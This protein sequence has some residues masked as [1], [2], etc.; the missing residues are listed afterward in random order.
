MSLNKQNGNNEGGTLRRVLVTG[1]AGYVGSH[2]TELL[3]ARGY[4]VRVFDAFLFDTHSLDHMRAWF[5]AGK[6]C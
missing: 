1:G 2:L 3:L 5:A 4:R 6:Y